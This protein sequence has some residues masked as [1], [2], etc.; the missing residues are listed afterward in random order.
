MNFGR[1]QKRVAW[2]PM[3]MFT[4]DDKDKIIHYH[5]C[6]WNP[7]LM[8]E[9]LLSSTKGPLFMKCILF[10]VNNEHFPI[11]LQTKRHISKLIRSNPFFLY[12][13][14]QPVRSIHSDCMLIDERICFSPSPFG[15]KEIQF[16]SF[17]VGFI[18]HLCN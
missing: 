8:I 6:Q 1:H 11:V 2:L 9:K 3:L 15:W 5:C 16:T 18:S 12:N 10:M 7:F 14:N 13:M 17:C 4:L